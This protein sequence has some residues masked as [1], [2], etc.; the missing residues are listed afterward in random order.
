MQVDG[1]NGVWTLTVFLTGIAADTPARA[2][3]AKFMG[4]SAYR[5]CPWCIWP[6][7]RR[8]QP[9]RQG[10]YFSH[11]PK[12]FPYPISRDCRPGDAA[13]KLTDR[14]M[15]VLGSTVEAAY[16]Q[17]QRQVRLQFAGSDVL[18]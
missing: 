11:A 16:L 15:R 17:G 6:G 2:K 18:M 14:A 9:E 10:T 8:P 5:A 7:E 1:P 12:P 4:V 3:I 13:L